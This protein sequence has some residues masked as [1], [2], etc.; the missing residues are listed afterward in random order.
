M[1]SFDPSSSSSFDLEDEDW[2]IDTITT[3]QV[4]TLIEAIDQIA[5]KY[6]TK[7]HDKLCVTIIHQAAF[8]IHVVSETERGHRHLTKLVD[9]LG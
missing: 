3:S 1:E 2:L 7:R 4:D 5:I 8:I 6:Q 9:Y